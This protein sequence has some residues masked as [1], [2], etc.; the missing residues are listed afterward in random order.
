MQVPYKDVGIFLN[1]TDTSFW[2]K[3]DVGPMKM[4][5]KLDPL[6]RAVHETEARW[7]VPDVELSD[8]LID[9]STWTLLCCVL[10][11]LHE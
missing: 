11:P 4:E 5:W 10:L 9:V 2:L 3:N 7:W 1:I 8:V 6:V